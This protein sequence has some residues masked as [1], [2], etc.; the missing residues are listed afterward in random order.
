MIDTYTVPAGDGVHVRVMPLHP[1]VS[2]LM[3]SHRLDAQTWHD[4]LR[5]NDC[6]C[7]RGLA[8]ETC[9]E[10]GGIMVRTGTCYTCTV[11]G[12]TGGCG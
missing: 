8:G 9:H 2:A 6:A 5:A 7:K 4:N 11:C 1:S 10:C 12:E 3:R